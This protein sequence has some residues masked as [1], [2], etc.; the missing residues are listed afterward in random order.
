[1]SKSCITNNT[2]KEI[3]TNVGGKPNMV[4]KALCELGG[5][6]DGFRFKIR[7]GKVNLSSKYLCSLYSLRQFLS[8]CIR[9]TILLAL[10]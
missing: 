6:S 8:L 1:M 3:V 7:L 4:H 2:I 5:V 9:W 10:L